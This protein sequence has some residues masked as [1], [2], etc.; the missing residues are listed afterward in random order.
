MRQP[1]NLSSAERGLSLWLQ[2]FDRPEYAPD[3][4]LLYGQEADNTD[5]DPQP[6]DFIGEWNATYAYPRL[7]P[8]D[9]A[10]FFCRAEQ[11]SDQLPVLRGDGG[12]YWED[13]ALTSLR[14]TVLAREAQARLPAAETLG[15][16]AAV[17]DHRLSLTGDPHAGAWLDLLLYD[18]HTWGAFMS[19][20]DP[21]ARLTRDQWAVKAAF[22]E[23][24]HLASRQG[25][26]AAA[27]RH[28]LQWNT[29]GRE[30]VVYNPHNW[31]LAAECS[32]EIANDEVPCDPD[33]EQ[34]P[35]RVL[36]QHP[37]QRVVAFCAAVPGLSYRRFTLQPQT[38][39]IAAITTDVTDESSVE[40]RSE[41]YALTFDLRL[42]RASLLT[43]LQSGE[44]LLAGG[45]AGGLV[46]V[47]GGE[48]SRILSNQADLPLAELH[49][50]EHFELIEA[51]RTTDSLG[52][53]LH[54][55]A[56]VPQG[57]LQLRVHLPA[58]EKRADFN[59]TYDKE[60]ATAR[61]A[62]YVRFDLDLPDARV[63]SD[64]QLG[65]TDWNTDRLP[66]ACLEWLPLQTG[67]LL[68]GQRTKVLV[69]SPDIPL[70]T[71]GDI[72][73]GA[74]PKTRDIRG[75]RIFGYLLSNYWHTNY[76]ARQGGPLTF[77]YHLTSGPDLT[78]E[79]A[80]R[81]GRS[82]RQGLYAH[83]ISFQDFRPPTASYA[84]PAGGT[85]AEVSENV[86]LSVLKPARDGRGVILRVQDLRG[87][88]QRAHARFA[89]RRICRATQ[90][91]LL[92][93]DLEPAEVHADTVHFAVPAWGL[94]TVRIEF[95]P[96]PTQEVQP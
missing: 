26:H 6:Q 55:R 76:Q 62:A 23:R 29:R 34:V 13:G 96:E 20:T 48:D 8:A 53:T 33:G 91:D 60:A 77:R 79:V 41:H 46:Y 89:P 43:E 21:D 65:W 81:V 30:V 70:F 75:G 5:L 22:A 66:G 9:P 18:E 44:Q 54:L 84:A 69:S 14:E 64:S 36:E 68:E 72:V 10:E 92:E 50:D 86:T 24:A 87:E 52:D 42:G 90:T 19:V 78:R 58:H 11:F 39:P 95:E 15:T 25:L 80:G 63:L 85:L 12:A 35:F 88:I 45:G 74:W 83:R 27:S 40:L 82:A 7:V 59:Y 49:D 56:R 51:S 61:E 71:A 28:S 73:R 94:T 38:V 2:E 57:S 67:M 93:Y 32:V 3:C 31:P 1:P 4:V 16:L 17:H 37:S 47:R